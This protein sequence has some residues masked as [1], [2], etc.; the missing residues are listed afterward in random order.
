MRSWWPFRN[1]ARARES[2]NVLLI[3]GMLATAVAIAGGKVMLDRSLAQR[4][5]NQL[6]EN[7][8]RAKEIPGSAAMIAKALI[9]LPPHVAGNKSIEWTSAKLESA[10]TN[11][12]MIY[13]IP[14]LSGTVGS[15]PQPATTVARTSAPQSGANWDMLNLA[16]ASGEAGAI[17]SASVNV[18]T[19]DSSR[20]SAQ[21]INS[22]ISTKTVASG[23]AT[24]KR[25]KSVV[26]YSFRN[27]DINNQSSATF[28]GRYCA[29][30][31]ITSDSYA[32]V[33]KG[34]D[35]ATG[36][37]NKVAVE[38]GGIEPPPPPLIKSVSTSD[39]GPLRK[40][41]NFSLVV[42][43]TGV[44]TG[45]TVKYGAAVLAQESN[46]RLSLAHLY[47]TRELVIPN[48]NSSA[49]SPA[50]D[51]PCQS[52]VV[53]DVTL[54]GITGIDPT[55][56]QSFDLAKNLVS[57]VPSSFNVTRIGSDQRTCKIE[58]KRDFG[59]GTVKKVTLAQKNETTGVVI[60]PAPSFSSPSFDAGGNWSTTSYP[61]SQDGFTFSGV[62]ERQSSCPVPSVS[63]CTPNKVLVPELKPNCDSFSIV[64]NA[65]SKNLCTAIVN[66]SPHSHWG[67]QVSLNSQT[68]TGGVWTG[69]QWK[70]TNYACGEAATIFSATLVKGAEV[71]PACASTT[72]E[73]KAFE[74]CER[75]STKVTRVGNTAKCTISM[76]KNAA[77]L[78]ADITTKIRDG[79]AMTG[80]NWVGHVWTSPPFDCGLGQTSYVGSFKGSDG[81][82]S[83]CGPA[84]LMARPPVCS[85]L[86]VGPPKGSPTSRDVTITKGATSGPVSSAVVNGIEISTQDS[87]TYTTSVPCP[88]TGCT[89][90]A[91]LVNN[92]GTANCPVKV[93]PW[94]NLIGTHLG[95]GYVKCAWQTQVRVNGA[96]WFSVGGNRFIGDATVPISKSMG[97]KEPPFCNVVDVRAVGVYGGFSNDCVGKVGAL[98]GGLC[99]VKGGTG[100]K[101]N[102]TFQFANQDD[103]C[104]NNTD[105]NTQIYID[106]SLLK[107]RVNA[108]AGKGS[109]N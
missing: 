19:N 43:A 49:L 52:S 50:F 99:G 33:V 66:R 80:G 24:I 75:S 2:G 48:I 7:N 65:G 21:D 18:Y 106:P 73:I 92:T 13:P 51:D 101:G 107:Y 95:T 61:C 41:T 26:T 27:C 84:V 109:C 85:N 59:T 68:Q 42:K 60:N 54:D 3:T 44:A 39:N 79:V 22:A 34:N 17:F 40:N 86:T 35:T 56:S 58:L 46:K 78:P 8:K 47:E 87:A 98:P 30:A 102:G 88:V 25:T 96:A 28:T 45:Y 90:T 83:S 38:L 89:I 63:V 12:P 74:W 76:T 82:I 69:N 15:S 4:K 104:D 72:N 67:V 103:I 6:A 71:S 70:M 62:L 10:A 55:F 31:V 91:S 16:N 5:A 29:S 36:A 93:V 1:S 20:A 14:Y 97:F 64:R 77:A 9:S 32:S 57:C 23:S 53:L 81:K 105:I 100:Y 11:R 94:T 108:I 37:V